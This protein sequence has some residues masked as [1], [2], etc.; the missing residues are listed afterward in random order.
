MDNDYFGGMGERIQLWA[1]AFDPRKEKESK[2][3]YHFIILAYSVE[4]VNSNRFRI[5]S[6]DT[7]ITYIPYTTYSTYNAHVAILF[8]IK[9]NTY[10][11]ECNRKAREMVSSY[12]PPYYTWK[13]ER[14]HRSD[15]GFMEGERLWI[16]GIKESKPKRSGLKIG[17]NASGLSK[18]RCFESFY[19]A[20]NLNPA[21]PSATSKSKEHSKAIERRLNLWR[22]G[23]LELLLKEVR[24]IPR[25]Y[26]KESYPQLIKLLDSKS[27]TGLLNLTPEVLE[28]QKEKHPKG[29]DIVDENLL[30]GPSD[31]I[32]PGVFDLIDEKMIFDAATKTKGSAGP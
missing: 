2:Q 20:P 5:F 9:N 28:G 14:L 26:S 10:N 29:A 4:H 27:S 25:E 19:G 31:Y 15:E 22:Q 16:P 23:D 13:E 1:K 17:K 11:T 30:Y 6:M 21:K 12:N 18:L 7:Y 8:T 24:F 32:P 3:A